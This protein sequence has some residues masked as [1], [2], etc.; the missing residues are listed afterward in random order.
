[1][2]TFKKD[3]T[4]KSREFDIQKNDFVSKVIKKTAT[5]KELSESDPDQKEIIFTIWGLWEG[6]KSVGTSEKNIVANPNILSGLM[7]S[8]IEKMLVIKQPSDA[9]E[10]LTYQESRELL[11]DNVALVRLAKWFV[12]E[13][14]SFFFVNQETSYSI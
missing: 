1:M 5:F 3:I 10:S 12:T 14:I 8:I 9:I 11:L 7:T 6:V 13:K 4:Y 2:E